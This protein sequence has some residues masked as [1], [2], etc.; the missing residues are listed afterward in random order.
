[1]KNLLSKYS[2]YYKIDFFIYQNYREVFSA[3][4]IS[5]IIVSN[6]SIKTINL[7]N[8]LDDQTYKLDFEVICVDQ[9]ESSSLK[10][11]CKKLGFNM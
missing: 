3:I 2:I 9:V 5:F 10:Q 1:M 6:V 4:N 7:L 11:V 8:N